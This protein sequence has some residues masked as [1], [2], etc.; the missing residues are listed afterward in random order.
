MDEYMQQGSLEWLQWRKDKLGASDAAI[1]L[2]KSPWMTPGQLWEE[3]LGFREPQ[4]M[5]PSMKR[6]HDLEEQARR[7]YERMVNVL[8]FPK[9]IV[10][11]EYDYIIASLDGITLDDTRMVEIKCPG[12]A[13]YEMAKQGDIPEYYEIQMQ[14][15]M[16]VTDLKSCDYFCYNGKEGQWI[17]HKRD[18]EFIDKELLPKL[19]WFKE[20]LEKQNPPLDADD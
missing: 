14:H 16:L 5:N 1:I 18:D 4:R 2:G 19:K 13:I 20:C 3:K 11:P 15:Q 6:G 7:L 9:V 17:I 8:V 10:H 12:K